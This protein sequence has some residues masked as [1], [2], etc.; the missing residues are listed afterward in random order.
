MLSRAKRYDVIEKN[1]A[2][3]EYVK[4]VPA[5][6]KDTPIMDLDD[7]LKAL[8]CL[9]KE[10]N[11]RAVTAI[12]IGIYMGRRRGE[13][14]GLMWTDI[15]LEE[16]EMTVERS[17]TLTCCWKRGCGE[18]TKDQILSKNICHAINAHSTA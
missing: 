4:G 7:T 5:K 14:A 18:S 17:V 2:S 15:D 3:S 1:Y 6:A 13:V 10:E 9:K 12:M 8:K 16:G 11:I